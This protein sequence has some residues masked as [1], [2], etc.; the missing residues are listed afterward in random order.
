MIRLA[1]SQKPVC[2][3]QLVPAH[4]GPPLAKVARHSAIDDVGRV[5]NPLIVHGQTHG[6]IVGGLGQAMMED[7]VYADGSGQLLTG[8]F[9]D[10]AMP[11]ADDWPNFRVDTYEVIAPSNP[12]GVKGGGEGG[13]I[14]ALAAFTN[15]VVDALREFGVRHVDMPVTP[16]RVWRAINEAKGSRPSPS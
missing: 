5:I 3:L 10:Y 15:A 1:R 13:T 8:S 4:R 11:R 14:P 16:E 6:G 7:A 12:L 2:H 9:M